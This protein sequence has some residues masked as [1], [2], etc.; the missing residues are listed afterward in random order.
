MTRMDILHV[1]SA[2][3]PAYAYGGPPQSVSSLARAQARAGYDVT[4]Y[5]TDTLDADSRVTEYHNPA[6]SDGVTVRRYRNLS[7]RLAWRNLPVAPGLLPAVARADVDIVHT[8]EYRTPNCVLAHLGA[9][10]AQTPHV[11]QP[12]G[13]ASPSGP[14][15][16]KRLFDAY[17]RRIVAGADALVASSSG[18]VDHLRAVSPTVIGD[19]VHR[20]PNGLDFE[21]Y[22][23]L[24]GPGSFREELGI[25]AAQPL[26]LYV[27]RL[28]ERKGL[29]T[30]VDA[31]SRVRESWPGVHLAIVG[32]DEGARDA[33]ECRA[34]NRGLSD[35]VSLTGPRYD[36]ALVAAYRDADVFVLPSTDTAESFGR[37]VVEALA[38]GTPAVV[39]DVCG[40]VEWVDS[41]F[42]TVVDPDVGAIATGIAATLDGTFDREAMRA[43]VREAFSWDAVARRTVEVYESVR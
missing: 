19:A 33:I 39:T 24:P 13:S 9:H 37:V 35:S 2:Y 29:T 23:T 32:P 11:L 12:R 5:T 41:A 8:H 26:V 17:G 38:A 42:A 22:E 31:V 43:H 28:H 25:E 14:T 16:A 10:I 15:A 3:P 30:L 36:E 6:A 1:V 27:G 20:V 40:V 4:V 34:E 21:P 7:N 18:E